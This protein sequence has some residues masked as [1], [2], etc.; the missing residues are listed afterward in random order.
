MEFEWDEAKRQKVLAERGVDLARA[1]RIFDG[2]VLSR[3]D[4]RMAYG[5]VRWVSVGTI[6]GI[7]YT[8]VHAGR[9]EAIRLITAWKGGR[10]ELER[11]TA[12]LFGRDP[13]DG[14][15]R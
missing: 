9:G 10:D 5:E 15:S 11:Y 12:S 14:G 8:V 6:D 2:P 7:A 13:R 3:L 4:R 1:A